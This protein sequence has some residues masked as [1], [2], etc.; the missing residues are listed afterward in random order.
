MGCGKTTLGRALA[1]A[2]GREFIDLD[3]IIEQRHHA[4]VSQIFAERGEEG[5]RR[6][7]QQM[8]HEVAEF[9]DC[10]ISCGGGTPCFFDNMD[11]MNSRGTTLWL[12]ASEP[13]LFSRLTRKREKR[14]LI[15]GKTDDQIRTIISEQLATRAPFYSRAQWQWQ[16]D[17]LEDKRQISDTVKA[18]LESHNL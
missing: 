8:L 16:G 13:T 18:F 12:Q 5:F 11:Y 10:I 15:A 3:F 17:M 4:T 2:T 6:L 9:E 7:E 14:P 1:A